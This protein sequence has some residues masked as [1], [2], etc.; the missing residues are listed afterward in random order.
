MRD[1][2]FCAEKKFTNEYAVV[3][4]LSFSNAWEVSDAHSSTDIP[5]Y[6]MFFNKTWMRQF[7][8][9]NVTL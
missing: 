1:R 9:G 3:F 6:Q 4:Q 5:W 7:I 8:V 2:F